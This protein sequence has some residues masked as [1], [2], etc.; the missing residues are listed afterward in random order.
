MMTRVRAPRS[1]FLDFPLGR[2]CGK[3]NDAD[4]QSRILKD[5]LN[6]LVSAKTPGT[7]VDLNYQWH[8]PFDW[9]T[10]L[11]DTKAMLEEQGSGRREWIPKK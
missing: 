8:E 7:L 2:Q 5:A 10:Y 11:A 4:L 3:P 1:V 9:D 6:V